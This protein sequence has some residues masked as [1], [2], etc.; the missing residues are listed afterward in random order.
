MVD[1]LDVVFHAL[2]S[3]PRRTMLN[4]LAGGERSVGELAEPF[5]ISLA[6]VSKHLFVLEDAGLVERRVEGRSTICRLRAAP[7]ADVRE[8]VAFYEGFWN[9]RL[10]RLEQLM[11]EED[12]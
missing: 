8:W 4:A 10:D 3:A 5:A 7:L 11:T 1:N 12:R 2:S 6:A 9:S